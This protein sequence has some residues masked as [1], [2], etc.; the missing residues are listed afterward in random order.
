[1]N[2]MEPG[3]IRFIMLFR[4]EALSIPLIQTLV[5]REECSRDDGG[6]R[7]LFQD[8]GAP[9]SEEQFFVDEEDFDQL[10]LDIHGLAKRVSEISRSTL[11]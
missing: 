4:D 7:Y 9:A 3:D 8:L 5:F 2:K 10:V 6:R 11:K 1:M